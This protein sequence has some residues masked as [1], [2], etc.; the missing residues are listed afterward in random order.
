[1]AKISLH[2]YNREIENLIERGLTEEAIGHCKY[3]LEQF[4][5]HINTYRLLGKTY[6][7]SQRY[8]EAA[9]IL[10]RVLSSI[11]DDFVSQLGMSIIREDE[12][13]LDAAIWH[14]ERAYEVQPANTAVQDELR[15]LYG[16]R[17]GVEPPK[18]RLTRGALVRMYA[19]GELYTQAI[20]EARAALAEDAQRIDLE[21][22]LAQMYYLAGMLVE[23][24]EVCGRLV[25]KLPYC[26]EANRILSEI[27][28]STSR[29]DDAKVFQQN[30]YALD[31]YAAFVSPTALTGVRDPE[32][33][34][35]IERLDWTPSIADQQPDWVRTIG[36]DYRQERSDLPDWLDSLP[37]SLLASAPLHPE[38]EPLTEETLDFS[39]NIS[40]IEPSQIPEWMREAGWTEEG[41][42]GKE[43]S[44]SV[45]DL[46]GTEAEDLAEAQLPA[47]LKELAPE[48]A[49]ITPEEQERL[50]LLDKILPPDTATGVPFE[51]DEVAQ[52]E[53]EVFAEEAE[54]NGDE[55]G[56]VTGESEAEA[57]QWVSEIGIVEDSTVYK[58]GRTGALP[59]WLEQEFEADTSD[60][61]QLPEDELP[62]WLRTDGQEETPVPHLL[63]PEETSDQIAIGSDDDVL[64]G[65]ARLE[66]LAENQKAEAE[67]LITSPEEHLETPPEWATH[68]IDEQSIAPAT[69]PSRA[70]VE[71]AEAEEAFNEVRP[72]GERQLTETGEE[73]AFAWLESLATRQGAGEE[74]LLTVPEDR[75]ETPPEW[76]FEETGI[77]ATTVETKLDHLGDEIE[78]QP[79][80]IPGWIEEIAREEEEV[81]AGSETGAEEPPSD[82]F[83]ELSFEAPELP[84][85]T[86][87]DTIAIAEPVSEKEQELPAWFK[88]IEPDAPQPEAEI[89]EPEIDL[90]HPEEES[91]GPV[92]TA[93]I[94]S[95]FS[96]ERIAQPVIAIPA[97]AEA[98][99]KGMDQAGEPL[100]SI[101]ELQVEA[102]LAEVDTSVISEEFP[103]TPAAEP[104]V[105]YEQPVVDIV[106][107]L[108]GTP[109]PAADER[110]FQQR[111][112]EDMPETRRE[113]AFTFLERGEIDAAI[114]QYNQMIESG[115]LVDVVIEDLRKALDRH[116]VDI[117]IWQALGDAYLR[118]DQVQE[119]LDSYTKAEELL[120]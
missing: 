87:E 69:E 53:A 71:N 62:E 20:A 25:G 104:P 99:D 81:A 21:I 45:F 102:E 54:R 113:Q 17:D 55:F 66:P 107:S 18:V 103:A 97:V 1:M 13:N 48:E 116:P 89:S 31:P 67:T 10:Q 96:E 72:Q 23:A 59:S 65:I 57:S 42:K 112:S 47:W 36:A 44:P 34:V 118:K 11:P 92:E 22:I 114:E 32:T 83:A 8:S 58:T 19:R 50:A 93:A 79:A 40:Q 46:A 63:K 24:A 51:K 91:I 106:L 43:V 33:V 35:Q 15:R 3:V 27:L 6:L 78:T 70:I 90:L 4:P 5:K 7:E 64:A 82:W 49:E 115:E 2:A 37:A 56:E 84:V 75:V 30:L 28:P 101:K 61:G 109:E 9:D 60:I 110:I 98:V 76:V 38:P 39:S 29:S 14:M 111:I 80:E 88:E 119:A 94:E 117:T 120:R 86:A 100:D 16:R 108:D 105:E 85:T 26:F 68:K 73:D 77:P 95:G 41:E 52:I 12:G 74:T